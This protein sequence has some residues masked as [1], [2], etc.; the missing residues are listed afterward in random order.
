MTLLI[1]QVN[2]YLP[3][4]GLLSILF[5]LYL[6]NVYLGRFKLRF[7]WFFELSH[8]I[9]GFLVA[10]L[11]SNFFSEVW[12]VILGTMTVGLLYEIWEIIIVK[13]SKISNFLE[14]KF[15]YYVMGV[16]PADTLLDISLDFAGVIL[17]VILF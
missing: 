2:F 7:Y 12:L 11:L 6:I 5:I 16:T 9:G 1:S 8:F 14:R 4:I 10:M 13:N 3:V 17:F 15:K